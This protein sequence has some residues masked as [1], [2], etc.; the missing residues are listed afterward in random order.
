MISRPGRNRLAKRA[1]EA[2]RLGSLFLPGLLDHQGA[3]SV[4][5]LTDQRLLR[6]VVATFLH[7]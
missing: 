2:L 1:L 3:L 6:E 5:L 4:L 7:R